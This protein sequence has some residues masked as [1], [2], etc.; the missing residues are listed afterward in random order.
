MVCPVYSV[1]G[2]NS[3][4]YDNCTIQIPE[5]HLHHR[6]IFIHEIVHFLQRTCE[7]L[8]ET[9]KGMESQTYEHYQDYVNQ[10]SE[11]EAHYVQLN[12]ILRHEAHLIPEQHTEAFTIP[13]LL[14]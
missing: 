5:K 9:Y 10:R 8:G 4:A 6:H 3:C 11:R 2:H 13:L 1:E 7:E 12:Y 14:H